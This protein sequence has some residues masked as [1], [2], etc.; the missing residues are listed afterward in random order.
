MTVEPAPNLKLRPIARRRAYEEVVDQIRE[1]ILAGRLKS[2]DRLPG[3]RQLSEILGVSRSSVREALRVLENAH[4]VRAR[5]GTGAESGSIIVNEVGRPMGDVLL[6]HTALDHLSLDE[7]VGVR[8]A[9]EGYGMQQ[10]ALRRTE[11]DLAVIADL[12]D[13]MDDRAITPAQFLELDTSFHMAAAKASGNRLNEFLMQ[14]IRETIVHML[15]DILTRSEDWPALHA[16]L[17][18]EHRAVH[19]AIAEGDGDRASRLVQAHI[20]KS[21]ERFR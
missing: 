15:G 21:H 6:M 5:A 1:E 12:V 9:L 3:E 17:A 2:G 13:R 16:E 14:S 7:V 8:I 11:E 10:A 18:R 19:D 20:G 4:I